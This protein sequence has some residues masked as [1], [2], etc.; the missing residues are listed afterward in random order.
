MATRGRSSSLPGLVERAVEFER[1]ALALDP[2]N[3][4]A[5]AWLGTAYLNMGQFDEAIASIRQ[6]VRLEPDNASARSALARAYWLGKGD[7][8]AAIAEFREV[9]ALNPEGGYAFLQLSLLLALRGEYAEA[10][11]VARTAIDLQ[12][13]FISGAEGLQIIGAHSRL[14]YALYLQGRYDEAIAEYDRE[15]AFIGAGDHALRERSTIEVMQKLGAAWLRKGRPEEAARYFTSAAQA[16]EARLTNG[17][18]DPATRYYMA[19]LEALR[20]NH[21]HAIEHLGRS[22]GTLRAIG[23]VRASVD[24]DLQ[25][26]RSDP[27]FVAL[28][29]AGV[30]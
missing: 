1:R 13:R 29:A 24:P 4:R 6:A 10:E 21:D 23:L 3:A 7:V 30:Q 15:L 18:D 22:L 25:S 19:D 17:A 20:G 27:R 16:F 5:H 28:L 14:G 12:E 9:V 8:N 2:E 26:I 11:R